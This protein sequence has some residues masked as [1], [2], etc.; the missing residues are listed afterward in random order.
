M[1]ESFQCVHLPVFLPAMQLAEDEVHSIT[2]LAHSA[3]GTQAF[4]IN[5]PP[6]TA[7]P[8]QA[9]WPLL[10]IKVDMPLKP[11]ARVATIPMCWSSPPILSGAVTGALVAVGIT[12]GC[13]IGRS[14]VPS[15]QIR[16]FGFRPKKIAWL[17]GRLVRSAMPRKS[18]PLTLS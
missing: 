4:A 10:I 9:R 6:A 5:T 12:H 8:S 15:S 2:T 16:L 14:C 3:I 7:H 18:T 11:S 13:A 17:G 1:S